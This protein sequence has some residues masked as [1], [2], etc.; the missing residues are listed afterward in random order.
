MWA[1]WPNIDHGCP[2][3]NTRCYTS[4]G[5]S[6]KTIKI[7]NT[8]YHIQCSCLFISS[9]SVMIN[10]GG[11]RHE[12][13]IYERASHPCNIKVTWTQPP[14]LPNRFRVFN[15][16]LVPVSYQPKKNNTIA[17]QYLRAF[18]SAHSN[19]IIPSLQILG[20]QSQFWGQMFQTQKIN[21]CRNRPQVRA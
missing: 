17:A 15:F 10:R 6:S 1:C 19:T 2:W 4:F 18:M 20:L 12:I 21:I 11:E 8:K 5:R 16:Q 7:D 14:P 13:I 3:C 9:E